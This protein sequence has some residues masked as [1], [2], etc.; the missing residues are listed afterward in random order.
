MPQS[1]VVAPDADEPFPPEEAEEDGA[2]GFHNAP[3]YLSARTGQNI[4]TIVMMALVLID[5]DTQRLHLASKLHFNVVG[6]HNPCG[7]FYPNA[8]RY[9]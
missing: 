2:E 3:A 9:S 6:I 1:D 7:I 5:V 4:P 8:C